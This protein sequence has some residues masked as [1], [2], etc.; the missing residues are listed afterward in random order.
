MSLLKKLSWYRHR[1]SAMSLEEVRCRLIAK[2]RVW[3]EAGFIEKLKDSEVTN[4]SYA[5]YLEIL[6]AFHSVFFS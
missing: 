5:H 6:F 4:L 2:W 3:T 1:L